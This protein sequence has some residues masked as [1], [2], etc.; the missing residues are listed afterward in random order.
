MLTTVGQ[1]ECEH[2]HDCDHDD[3]D[4]TWNVVI[5]SCSRFPPGILIIGRNLVV[6]RDPVS[7]EFW[8]P[9]DPEEGSCELEDYPR[10]I[11]FTPTAN[12]VS[13]RLVAC[14]EDSCEI[15]NNGDWNH[16]VNT[17]SSRINHSSAVKENRILLIGGSVSNSTEWISA[18]G[19][20]SQAGPFQVRHGPSHCTIQPYADLI[21]LTGG[22]E[23]EEYV[24]EYQ[25]NG[26]STETHLSE[27][28]QGRRYHACG[29]Y[30]G[31]GS[32]QVS[33]LELRV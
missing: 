4:K 15:Y 29:V 14:Y 20:P 9:A 17:R 26:E 28:S 31:A 22:Y 24:T 5:Y 6:G 23:T 10:G 2:F 33:S 19:S 30:Q 13:G 32:Q 8:S 25:L 7:V 1:R 11:D 27:M 16:L 12:L 3:A 21:V 18:D